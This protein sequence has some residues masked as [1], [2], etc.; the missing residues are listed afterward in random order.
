MRKHNGMRPQDVAI[1]LKIVSLGQKTWQLSSLANSLRISISEIS[2]SLNR[3]QISGLIERI[4]KELSVLSYGIFLV[5]YILVLWIGNWM[6]DILNLNAGIEQFLIAILTFV[7]A[8][9]IVKIISLVPK[10]K[11]IIG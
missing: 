8:Y 7:I 2:E 6:K 5:H 1:L 11:Y 10:S 9:G 3:S 4:F